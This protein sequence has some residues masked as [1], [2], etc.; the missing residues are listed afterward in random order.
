MTRK[1]N[2]EAAEK[3]EQ[4]RKA[5]DTCVTV[6]QVMAITGLSRNTIHSHVRAL[7]RE[8][9]LEQVKH[10][11][12]SGEEATYRLTTINRDGVQGQ[13]LSYLRD[14]H[15]PTELAQKL[16]VSRSLIGYHLKILMM[17]QKVKV[18]DA[19][20]KHASKPTYIYQVRAIEH[21]LWP[22]QQIK[23]N[24]SGLGRVINGVDRY[25]WT[26]TA[27]KPQS[28]WVGS[29]FSTMAF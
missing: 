21:S 18:V 11:L 15:T 20:N 19:I 24:P 25:E 6:N 8:E 29:T 26:K 14:R 12:K 1:L 13:I 7:I 9:Y 5:F 27:R 28:A 22:S 17:Q 10:N 16:N 23:H 2:A 3:R 4:I